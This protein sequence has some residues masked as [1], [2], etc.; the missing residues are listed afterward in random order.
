MGM[1]LTGNIQLWIQFGIFRFFQIN[2]FG[3]RFTDAN[4]VSHVHVSDVIKPRKNFKHFHDKKI[5]KE[6]KNI[7][8]LLG[9]YGKIDFIHSIL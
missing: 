6:L 4:F 1:K 8:R 7:C 3:F 2:F 5:E 9:Y